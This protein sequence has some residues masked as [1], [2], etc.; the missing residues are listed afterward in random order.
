MR[1]LAQLQRVGI[2][3][4]IIDGDQVAA[5]ARQGVVQG[6]GLGLGR[7]GRHDQ[8]LKP[9]RSGQVQRSLDRRDVIRLKRKKAFETIAR[10]VDAGQ[11]F[12]QLRQDGRLLIQGR[13][14]RIARP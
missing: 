13:H 11:P 5:T 9:V 14:N 3:F 8:H 2:V 6:A 4:C 7:A 1:G 10:I 12:D